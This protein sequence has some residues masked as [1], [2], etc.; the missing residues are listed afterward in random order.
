M[1]ATQA[2][3]T[4]TGAASVAGLAAAVASGAGGFIV[5]IFLG[6]AISKAKA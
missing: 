4:A 6:L 5:G 3:A 1:A 2:G